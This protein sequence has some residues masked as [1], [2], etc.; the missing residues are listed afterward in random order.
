MCKLQQAEIWNYE[1]SSKKIAF[2]ESFGN[3][4]ID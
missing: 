2:K 3:L 4:I 1:K